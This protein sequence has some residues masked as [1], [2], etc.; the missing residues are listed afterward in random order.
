MLRPRSLVMLLLA[1]AVLSACAKRPHG[2][3]READGAWATDEVLRR[4]HAEAVA[5]VNRWPAF[6]FGFGYD[7]WGWPGP[8]PFWPGWGVGFGY[9]PGWGV[10]RLEAIQDMTAFCMR[11]QGYRRAPLP[12]EPAT[13]AP[14]E[15]PP[16]ARP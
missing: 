13:P 9:A 7:G 3:Q 12:E 8:R 1:A 4:C 10:S 6:A 11:V 5:Q 15:K 16:P 2:W 14:E